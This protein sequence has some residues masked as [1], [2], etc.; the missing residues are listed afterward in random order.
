MIDFEM[1][2]IQSLQH[3]F[4]EAEIQGCLFHFCQC[5]WRLGL[6][7]WYRD[8]ANNVLIIK[9]FQALAFVPPNRVTEAFQELMGSL[10]DETDELLSDFLSYYEATWIDVVVDAVL[11][12]PSLCGM[13]VNSRVEQDLS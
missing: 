11:C 12:S 13:H 4:P 3:H 2:A 8:D 5:L 9:S 7:G 1:A 6:Q 10:D